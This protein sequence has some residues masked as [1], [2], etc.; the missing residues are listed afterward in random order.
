MGNNTAYVSVGKPKI[1]GAI[2]NAPAGTTLPTDATTAL[3]NAYK[4]LGY[5]SEDGVSNANGA[6][7]DNIV[8][9]GKDI[10]L[11]FQT[12]KEDTWA[13]TLIESLNVD[14]LKAVYGADNVT[15]D[16]TTGVTVRA[17]NEPQEASVWVIE[18]K[19]TGDVSKRVVIPNGLLTG[20]EDI[21]YRDE[22]PIGY[23]ATITALPGDEDFDYDTHKEYIKKV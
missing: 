23:G 21:T 3:P 11:S 16:L 2:Y 6:S 18:M 7:S 19:L 22:E 5:V 10:V 8:A 20:L 4:C 13:F 15:G 1:G 12:E 9:W 17:N 14:V